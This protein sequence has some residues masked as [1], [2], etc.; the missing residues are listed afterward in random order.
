[1]KIIRIKVFK[2]LLL[3]FFFILGFAGISQTTIWSEN[4]NGYANGTENG[5]GTGASPAN[6][7]TTITGKVW[8]QGNRIEVTN[9]GTEGI[10]STSPIDISNYTGVTFSLNVATQADTSQ[11]EQGSDY[12]I[13]EYRIDGAASWT[14]FENASGDSAPSDPLQ[15]SYSINLPTTGSALEIR[16]RFYNTANNEFY[17]IDDVLVQ[18]TPYYCPG[19]LNFEFY[20]SVPAGATVNNIPTTGALGIGEYSSF[21]VDALQN[22]EDPG[23]TDSFS[24][25]FTGFINITTAGSY[26][27]YTTSDDGSKLY[28]D[29]VQIV[30]NDGNHGSQERNGSV[31]LTT[32][33]H[34]IEVLFFE[35]TGGENLSVQYQGPSISK[36]NIPFTI[37]YSD[38]GGSPPPIDTTDTDGD[39]VIDVNDL[40][41]DNDGILDGDECVG[42]TG[43]E[44]QTAS[45]IQYFS[46]VSNAE[47]VPGSTYAQ[48]PT[49]YPGGSSLLLL[50]FPSLV[51]IGTDL[52]IFLG[53]D[54]SVSASD[55]QI[56]RSDAAGNNNGYLA[57]GSTTLPGAI[58]QVTFTVT[59]TPLQYIR[60][61]AYNQG[62]RVYGANYGGG[63]GCDVDG[64]GII[65]SFDLD[66]DNDG[67]Y[68]AV[69]AGH[70]RNPYQWQA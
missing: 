20:D 22:Q 34:D 14:Q 42:A 28:I 43:G 13:G 61:E 37:L 46:N 9:L 33:F 39:G 56:Q 7:N 64:D 48:N 65:N 15:P 66:S 25:R 68:D 41:D 6:W 18:G 60:I 59:G 3:G 62:A 23:D 8:V 45:N 63:S 40:D 44:V 50:E 24:I 29:G 16:V 21:D 58:R 30:N 1:M 4:F 69:E 70:G 12:F 38:C 57:D 54:P 55:M 17:F 67:I 26:T 47:G 10:W 53:A 5:T 27:F 35:N 52:T 32:G 36:Q 19:E 31:T 11:F 49:T 2:K 51:P